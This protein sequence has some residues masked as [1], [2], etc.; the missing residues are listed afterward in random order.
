MS[1]PGL[2]QRLVLGSIV[3]L[4]LAVTA[5]AQQLTIVKRTN[6]TDNN[7]PPGLFVPAGSTV[8]FT[9]AV[10]FTGSS[11]QNVTVTDD[12]GTSG[13]FADDFNATFVGGD[14]NGNGF[15][16]PTETWTFSASRIATAGQYRNEGTVRVTSGNVQITT[17]EA[18]YHF[19]VAAAINVV[20]LTNGTDNNSPPGP[21]VP[22]GSTV[23]FTYIVTNP[24]NI[25]FV[26]NSV[27]VR[28]DNGTPGNP[29]DDFNPTFT[30]GDT[31]GNGLLD[32][33]ETWT[34]NGSRIATAGQYTNVATASGTDPVATS[35]TDT[36]P[37]N[38]FGVAPTATP[39]L[40][41]TDTATPT[42]T[43]TST[44]SGTPTATATAAPSATPLGGGA[45]S[46]PV[47]TLSFPMLALLGAALAAAGYFMI[48]RNL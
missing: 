31:N 19:G 20:K 48:R 6:G 30:G 10:S 37:D 26:L 47:P 22:V 12:N 21:L 40:T 41:P 5:A 39:T 7:F 13:N 29:A 43:A 11:V 2:R 9:Y 35:V 1:H 18:D 34:F 45:P 17:S 28:D 16:D 36:D 25:A 15:L 44:P 33:T 42:P 23:T 38:H 4:S 14:T 24:G 8:T 32:T 27:I 46:P 3:W